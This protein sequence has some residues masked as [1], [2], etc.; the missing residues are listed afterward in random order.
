MVWRKE[1]INFENA[2]K[3]NDLSV[4]QEIIWVK[5]SLVLGRQDYQWKHEPCLYGWKEG[6]SHYFID[7][8]TQ[9]TVQEDVV[10]DFSKMK[11]EELVQ[12]CKDL[13]SD[14]TS[15]TIIHEDR[16]AVSDLHPTMKPIKLIARLIKK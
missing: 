16:P 13:F 7:D 3:S 12:F 9:T 14:K 5:N 2:L 11:K 6:A 15:T 10:K 1:H 4:R 8:R